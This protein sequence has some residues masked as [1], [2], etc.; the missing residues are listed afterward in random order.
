MELDIKDSKEALVSLSSTG[1][2]VLRAPRDIVGSRG[3]VRVEN[4]KGIFQ[5]SHLGLCFEQTESG[6]SLAYLG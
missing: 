2:Q 1:I 6:K 4:A 3:E 5:V